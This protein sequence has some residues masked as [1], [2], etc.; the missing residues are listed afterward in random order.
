MNQQ[1]ID[2]YNSTGMEATEKFAE[3]FG[4][5][6]KGGEVIELIGDVGAGKTA[7]V[8]GLA[9]GIGSTDR[10]SSPTFTVS[11]VYASKNMNLH[12]Y[13]FYR[14][15]DL[16]IITRDLAEVIEDGKNSVV[17]EWADGVQGVLPHDHISIK[18]EVTGEIS[19][20]LTVTKP[21]KYDYI[22][23]NS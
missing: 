15:D 3:E 18:I 13:D 10:V 2:K 8:R 1:V 11:K 21:E 14:L 12:H 20:A 17:L 16:D 5:Q 7:F 23:V 4:R 9:R 19:R 6:L 22:K